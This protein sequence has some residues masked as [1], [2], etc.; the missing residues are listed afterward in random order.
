[1]LIETS[2]LQLGQTAKNEIGKKNL[3]VGIGLKIS[4]SVCA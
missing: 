3:M 4:C 1:M 2:A